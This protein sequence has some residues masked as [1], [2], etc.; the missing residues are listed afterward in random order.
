M[1]WRTNYCSRDNPP[2]LQLKDLNNSGH[3]KGPPG[4]S[5]F[6]RFRDADYWIDMRF[7]SRAPSTVN[8]YVY[9]PAPQL[10]TS[11]VKLW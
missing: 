5:P 7:V 6:I 9:M 8:V 3:K 10:L 11:S 4:G 2:P 1:I